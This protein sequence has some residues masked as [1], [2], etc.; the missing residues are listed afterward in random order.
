MTELKKENPF[1]R[2]LVSWILLIIFFIPTGIELLKSVEKHKHNPCTET[3]THFHQVH[4]SCL[5]CN[6]NFSN[7]QL[8]LDSN[9]DLESYVCFEKEQL[10]YFNSFSSNSTEDYHLRGPPKI[11]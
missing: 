1:I 6:F 4:D 7:Y 10:N 11:T 2:I 3:S 9:F 5:L 8:N